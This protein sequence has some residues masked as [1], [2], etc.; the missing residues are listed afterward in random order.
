MKTLKATLPA[1]L[2]SALVN[3]DSSGLSEDDEKWV[4]AAHDYAAPGY[5]VDVSEE[6]WFAWRNELPG[7]NLGCDVAEFTILYPE[8]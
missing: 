6:T 7:F 2:A 1:F 5:F 4:K 3:G 8:E